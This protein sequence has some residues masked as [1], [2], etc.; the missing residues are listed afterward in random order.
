M[1]KFEEAA[2]LI[3]NAK[4]L[5]SG[6]PTFR[7]SEDSVYEQ[8]DQSMLELNTYIRR[9]EEAWPV[10][11]K[12][13]YKFFKEAQPNAAHKILAQWEQEGLVKAVITQNIDSLHQ[14]V[15]DT[16]LE[17]FTSGPINYN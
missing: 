3:A 2:N 8:Y 14:A 10:V 15:I 12:V 5:E 11:N 16:L 13:F 1:N 4:C 9:T 17:P 6:I 7:G